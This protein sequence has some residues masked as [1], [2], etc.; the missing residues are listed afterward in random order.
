MMNIAETG[1]EPVIYSPPLSLHGAAAE[2]FRTYAG[3]DIQGRW[4]FKDMLLRHAFLQ[5]GPASY[6]KWKKSHEH[7]ARTPFL[8]LLNGTSVDMAEAWFECALET[9][10]RELPVAFCR[11][12]ILGG[13][14]K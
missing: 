14:I 4:I 12:M 9:S 2:V 8:E 10:L 1:V 3:L 6:G 5:D 13:V 7:I 11:G